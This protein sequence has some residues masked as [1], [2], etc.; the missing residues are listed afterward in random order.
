MNMRQVKVNGSDH[1][2]ALEGY[3][4]PVT[5]STTKE[6]HQDHNFSHQIYKLIDLLEGG[7]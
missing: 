3:I 4:H 5:K 6:R 2:L 7:F 1:H